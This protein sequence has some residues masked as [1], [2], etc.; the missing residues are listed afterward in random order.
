LGARVSEEKPD[1]GL[2][3]SLH[4]AAAHAYTKALNELLAA[5]GK[6]ALELFD[7]VG[8]TPL[9]CAVQQGHLDEASLILDAGANINA[10]DEKTISNTALATA[11]KEQNLAMVELLLK[12]GADPTIKGWV[13]LSA[14][15]RARDWNADG[16][17]PN[18]R[19]IFDLLDD[20]A[21]R[22]KLQ[23]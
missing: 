8:R 12:Y 19:R 2:G 11:V 1:G 18:L 20:A 6:V 15:D 17:A 23:R 5:D 4:R 21:K 16:T 3:T 7:D 22:R 14:L 9:I 10:H 13:Q